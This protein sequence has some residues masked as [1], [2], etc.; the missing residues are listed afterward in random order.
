MKKTLLAALAFAPIVSFAQTDT[1]IWMDF[2]TDPMPMLNL[3]PP[4]GGF[5]DPLW[6]NWDNDALPDGSGAGRPP[7]WYWGAPFSAT[8]SALGNTGVLSSNSWTNDGQT[9]VANWLVTPAIYIADTTADLYWKSAPF[10]T[11]RYLDGYFVAVSTGNND[12]T[13]FTDTLFRGSEYEALAV[14]AYPNQFSSYTFSPASG[15]IHG[16][17]QTYIEANGGDSARWRGVLRPFHADLSMYVGQSIYI[18]FVHYTIDDNLFSIDDIFLEGTGSVGITDYENTF[19]MSVYPNP[20]TDVLNINY[21]MTE[22]SQLLLNIYSMDGQLVRSE[23]KGTAQPGQGTMQ[24]DISDLA[25]GVYF[26]QLQTENG[27]TTKKIIVE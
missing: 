11:P 3:T 12:L 19:G 25:A 13:S 24:T 23:D 5:N 8:D 21:N 9:Y 26:V 14:P 2:E 6:Y 18:A 4:P 20:A 22:P 15:F 7:E 10:Q 16:F 27:V 1:I 17:D